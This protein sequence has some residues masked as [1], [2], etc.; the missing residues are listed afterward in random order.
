MLLYFSRVFVVLEAFFNWNRFAM[1]FKQVPRLRNAALGMTW[2]VMS[3]GAFAR[4]DTG[5]GDVCINAMGCDFCGV[6]VGFG[7]LFLSLKGL[8]YGSI[9]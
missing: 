4:D 5:W 2:G 1:L 9:C 8:E 3:H 6:I 7:L